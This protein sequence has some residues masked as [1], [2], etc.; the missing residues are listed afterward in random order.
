MRGQ[1]NRLRKKSR[2]AVLAGER[3]G[4]KGSWEGGEGGWDWKVGKGW[5]LKRS[6]ESG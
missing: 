1:G 4:E 3:E 5:G 6:W 2:F